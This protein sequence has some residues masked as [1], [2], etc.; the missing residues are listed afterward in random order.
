MEDVIDIRLA[1][2]PLG[3]GWQFG[4]SVAAGTENAWNAV[5][6]EDERAKPSWETLCAAHAEAVTAGQ[7]AALRAARDKRLSDT[8]KY[9]LADYPISA[10]NLEAVKLYRSALRGLPDAPGAPWDGGGESTPWPGVPD[11]IQAEQ[12]CA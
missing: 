9:T 11:I 3:T 2:E 5:V 8:D 7:Y 10:E 1:L 12:P 6:W 4:G